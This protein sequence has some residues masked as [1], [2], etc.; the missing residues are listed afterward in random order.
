MLNNGQTGEIIFVNPE[1]LARPMIKCGDQF[2]DL[3]RNRGLS[4]SA[5][6]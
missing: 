6:I 2:I 4:I 5:V 1:H 3:A